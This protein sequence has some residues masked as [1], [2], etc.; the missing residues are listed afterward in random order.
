[1]L[2]A[3]SLIG[4]DRLLAKDGPYFSQSATLYK[5][6]NMLMLASA[7]LVKYQ[8]NFFFLGIARKCWGLV[9]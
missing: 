7:I 6:I 2:G 4:L 1:M 8:R 5:P 9:P 3:C